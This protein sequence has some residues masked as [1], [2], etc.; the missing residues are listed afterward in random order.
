MT[1]IDEPLRIFVG[2]A[3]SEWIASKVLEHTIR[4]NT[5]YRVEF[6]PMLV[7]QPVPKKR[8]NRPRTAF[9]YKRF[10]IPALAGYRG[11]ALYMDSDMQVFADI[12]E[13]FAIPFGEAKVMCSLPRELEPGATELASRSH[14]GRGM[15]FMILDCSRLDWDADRIVADLDAGKYTYNDLMQRLCIL[16]ENEVV[17]RIPAEW[18]S[19]ERHEPGVTKNIHYT[20]IKTQPWRNDTNPLCA[21]W[22]RAYRETVATGA[23][24]LEDVLRSIRFGWAKPSLADAFP[25]GREIVDRISFRASCVATRAAKSIRRRVVGNSD[26]AFEPRL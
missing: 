18:N 6:S 4:A 2:A 13:V 1:G 15:A 25:G 8:E 24:Q 5:E 9:S 19:L 21:T 22:E 26:W 20:V 7:P 17:E 11:R 23:I 10:M 3:P 12:A 14:I 16:P